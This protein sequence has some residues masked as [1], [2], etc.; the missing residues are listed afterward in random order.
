ME[1]YLAD[2]VARCLALF[3]YEDARFLAERLV[4]AAPTEH[5]KY[6]LATCHWHCGQPYR[7]AHLLAGG[8]P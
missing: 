2:C 6:L 8:S 4:A 7:A 1:A 3:L 5:H